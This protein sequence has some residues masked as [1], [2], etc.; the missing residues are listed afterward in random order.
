MEYSKQ[1][2]ALTEQFEGCRLEAYQDI[3]GRWTC[4]YGHTSGVTQDTTC[5]QA[6]A[7]AWLQEDMSWAV[8]VVN[9][10]VTIQLSQG[11][12][13]ALVDFTFNLGSGSLAHSTLLQLVDA[14]DFTAAALEFDKWDHAGGQVVAGLLRRRQAETAEFQQAA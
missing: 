13:D 6:Q 4:G 14:G 3:V 5:T 7:E 2:V 8:G 9:A 10:L 12:F 11:E 1:G